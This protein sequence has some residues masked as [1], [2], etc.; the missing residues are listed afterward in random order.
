MTRRSANASFLPGHFVFPGGRVDEEDA[1]AH[2]LAA[3]P[4]GR[5]SPS[6]A[7]ALAALRET[8]EELGILLAVHPGGHPATPEECAQFR[9]DEPLYPQLRAAGLRLATN[10]LRQLARWITDRS[11]S[12]RRFDTA[13]LM[14]RMPEGQHPVAD[15]AEQFEPVWLKPAE[16]PSRHA[17]GRMPMIFP[18]LRTLD[19]LSQFAGAA[20]AIDACP[21]DQPLWVSCPRGGYREGAVRRFMEHEP[22][23]GELELVCPD[24]QLEHYLDWQHERPVPL[25]RHLQRLTAPNAG[26]MT[27]PGTNTYLIGTPSSGYIA[28]DPGPADPAHVERL[29]AATAGRIHAIIC[30]HSHLDHSPAARLLARACGASGAEPPILGLPSAPTARP[31]A[32]FH[33]SRVLADGERIVLDGEHPVTLR[34]I[35]T[36]GHAANHL[37]LLMEEDGLLLTGDHILGGTTTIVD[38]PDGDMTAY[39]DSLDRLAALC[40]ASRVD[41][42]LPGHGHAI[43][44]PLAA[45]AA[46]KAHR[47]QREV[48]VL[49]AL[50]AEP[51]GDPGTWIARAYD[52]TPS[53]LWPVAERSFLAHMIRL[54]RLGLIDID[55]PADP[56]G[57]APAAEVFP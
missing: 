44:E 3:V 30:T 45:I 21:A 33:P 7:F 1:A 15:G 35:H 48:K 39:L 32:V 31:D 11:V 28:A 29:M 14:A 41:F 49:E 36:P 24:G 19:W 56:R 4:Q 42:L 26:V 18:T 52:D 55:P 25:L 40:A 17:A 38:P 54:R 53:G 34:A 5:D 6:L 50:R 57:P 20:E 2:D 43:N 16:A 9:R 10:R 46:L 8:Y 13:F 12:P 27:G 37:C 22:G 23:F 51:D 47:L